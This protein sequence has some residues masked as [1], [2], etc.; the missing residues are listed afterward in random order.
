MAKA[1]VRTFFTATLGEALIVRAALGPGPAIIALNGPADGD[2]ALHRE[3]GVTA[4]LNSLPQVARWAA[5]E[6]GPCVIHIDTGMNRLGLRP[7]EAP[8]AARLLQAK[9][10]SVVMSHLACASDPHHPLNEAQ[11]RRLIDAASLFPEAR[12]S[13]AASAGAQLG[14]RFAFDLIR[15]GIGLYGWDGMDRPTTSLACA[16]RVLAPVLQRRRVPAGET[17]GYGATFTAAADL[18]AAILACGYADGFFRTGSGRAAIAY[19]GRRLR[20]L[21]R[22]SMDLLIVDATDAPDL[23]E[24]AWAEIVGPAAGAD[25]MAEA[26]GTVPYEVFTTFVGRAQKTYRAP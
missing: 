10:P 20:V 21:G 1:G 2:I 6:G 9:P 8:Q 13:L 26:A 17:C 24:G 4:C 15:P 25:A 22:I 3:H 12:R 18:D 16:A 14:P 5:A 19:E 11:R 7:E 23:E